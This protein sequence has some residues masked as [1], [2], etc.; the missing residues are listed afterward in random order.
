M[1]YL[2]KND[3]NND[4]IGWWSGG[5]TSAVAIWFA[6]KM[7]GLHRVR[8]IFIDTKNEYD[9]TYRFKDDCE[10]WYGK[11]IETISNPEYECIQDVWI[12]YKSLNVANGAICSSELKRAVRLKFQNENEYSAQIFGFD[13]DEAHRGT[14][15]TLNY[16]NA[17]PI[18]TLLMFGYTKRMAIKECEMNGI[19]IPDAYLKGYNNNNCG[20]TGC[21]QGG[22]GYWQ[23][24]QRLEPEQFYAMAMIEHELTELRGEPVT[25]LRDQSK[26]NPGLV[27]LLPHPKYPHIK[28]ISMMK[29]R[30]PKPLMECN[31][32]CGINDLSKPNKTIKELNFQQ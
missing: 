31:G 8:I 15:L 26:K 3:K 11:K 19:K 14:A 27:F 25:M 1:E 4:I 13:A 28:D 18:Y 17:K 21:V 16:P 6:I 7:F 12:K 10:K 29:G 2:V 32:M 5:V 24:K 23:M 30:P 22:I 9:D 20:K